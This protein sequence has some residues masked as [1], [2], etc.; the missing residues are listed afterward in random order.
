MKLPVRFPIGIRHAFRLVIDFVARVNLLTM[1]PRPSPINRI[2]K[3]LMESQAIVV[4]TVVLLSGSEI[5]R[6]KHLMSVGF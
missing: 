6:T 5:S 4:A 1:R 2:T 3:Y